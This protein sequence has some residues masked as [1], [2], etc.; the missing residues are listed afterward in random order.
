VRS[1]LTG[2]AGAIA[3]AARHAIGVRIRRFPITIELL[4]GAEPA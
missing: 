2:T 4:I 1:A 3:D